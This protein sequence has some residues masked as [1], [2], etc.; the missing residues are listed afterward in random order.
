MSKMTYKGKTVIGSGNSRLVVTTPTT[1]PHNLAKP[2][3][4][5]A[6]A[7]GVSA[8]EETTSVLPLAAPKIET[9]AAKAEEPKF[10]DRVW[11]TVK[12]AGKQSAGGY[13]AALNTL[14]AA[15]Q[16]VRDTQT[17]TFL[18]DAK[19]NLETAQRD[20]AI[21]ERYRKEFT[22]KEIADQQRMVEDLQKRVDTF[23]T[24]GDVQH[25]ATQT[26][27]EAVDKLSES[28]AADI[29]KAKEGLGTV[30]RFAVDVGAAGLGM[31][32]DTAT[33]AALGVGALP[34]MALRGFGSGAAEARQ[35]G[36]A[37]GDQIAYGI[38]S[39]A[40]SVATEKLFNMVKPF[41]KIFGKGATDDLVERAISRAVQ[42]AGKTAAGKTAIEGVL[43]AGT[44]FVGEG[45]EEFLE[46]VASPILKRMT[47][48][49]DAQFDLEQA[50][51]DFAVGGAL[52]ALGGSGE[53][54][55]EVQSKYRGYKARQPGGTDAQAPSAG[56]LT[57][58]A[59]NAAESL[60]T[61]ENDIRLLKTG[62]EIV[63]EGQKNSAPEAGAVNE[64]GLESLSE[65]ERSNLS[66]GDR[67]SVV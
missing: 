28:G 6:P 21:M 14:Y 9:P 65:Q 10:L 12:G 57:S 40:T 25:S 47:Y 39:A 35:E 59:E 29:E 50:I 64:N 37:L 60:K 23:G 11:D 67:K 38:G 46:S 8:K 43:R 48:D 22:E 15:G 36:A 63:A 16:N 61:P 49:P 41:A 32:G 42:R 55:T 31:L 20:L 34:A 27:N 33:G 44:G 4:A 58:G 62:E 30:G 56:N 51:Y 2:A 5:S 1:A 7:I 54:V 13:G 53:A 19:R 52:G 26:A 17:S 66:S 18:T 3:G 24:I 45:A